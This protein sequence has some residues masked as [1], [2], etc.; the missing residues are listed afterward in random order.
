[1]WTV[2]ELLDWTA[3]DF[4]EKGVDTAR[5]DAELLLA[6]AMQCS[7]LDLY[8]RFDDVPDENSLALFR[9]YVKRRRRREPVA[10]I[11]GKK[12]FHDIE[13]HI[14]PGVFISR[15][16]TEFLVDAAADRLKGIPAGKSKILD[17]GCGSGAVIL[18]ILNAVPLV[19]ACAV[20]L[21]PKAGENLMQNAKR[22][23]LKNR[24]RFF[25]GDLFEPVRD[26]GPF[27]MV[28]MNPPYIPTDEI[29]SLEPEVRDYEPYRALNGGPD[30][31]DVI[32]RLLNE[33]PPYIKYGGWLLFEIGEG[34]ADRVKELA[35][36]ELSSEEFRKDLQGIP[37]VAVFRRVRE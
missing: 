6:E 23:G 17:I 32:R 36:P 33:S 30:G 27:D 21:D 24:V 20:D 12:P 14:N 15:P 10:Y 35:P 25:C 2:K 4:A 22:L 9:E 8:L 31:L 19:Q 3:R 37:R 26:E 28:T 5:L 16:E 11:L 13:V 18:S 7:R 29:P 1:M 34:Q